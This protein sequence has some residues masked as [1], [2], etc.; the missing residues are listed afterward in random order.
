MF[1]AIKNLNLEPVY[2][3]NSIDINTIDANLTA[4][5]PKRISCYEDNVRNRPLSHGGD[6]PGFRPERISA[7]HSAPASQRCR[8]PV[9]GG[10]VRL[11]LPNRDLRRSGDRGSASLGEPLR[12]LG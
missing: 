11:A 10:P 6:L 12:A 3:I 7:F 8:G 2:V 9:H 4:V 5:K 1:R